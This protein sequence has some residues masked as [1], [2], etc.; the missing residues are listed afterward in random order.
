MS[1]EKKGTVLCVDDEPGILR[2]L[3]WLLQKDFDVKTAVGGE[4]GLRVVKE[5]DFDVIISDQRMPGMT[6][7]QFLAQAKTLSPRSM[8]LLLTG[9]SDVPAMISSV[10]EAEIWHFIKKPWDNDTLKGLVETAAKIAVESAGTSFKTPEQIADGDILLISV[11]E[12]VRRTL[13]ESLGEK[14]NIT[15][16]HSLLQAMQVLSTH[17]ST[18][19]IVSEAKLGSTDVTRFLSLLKQKRPEIV[20]VVMADEADVEQ[21]VT[22]INR[23]QIYRFVSK[24]LK[25]GYLKL[26]VG[27]ALAKHV[28]LAASPT[29]RARHTTKRDDT[30]EQALLQEMELA[31]ADSNYEKGEVVGS[32]DRIRSSFKKLFGRRGDSPR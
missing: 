1:Q 12:D 23:G 5:N 19:T 29:M 30:L 3:Q 20:S 17:E 7:A 16:A 25:K 11:D 22:L 21:L 8:R 26:V 9:Y 2:S 6:G 15:Y 28:Q 14:A 24:P 13:K 27:S 10:N 18:G 4:D 32:F 31:D